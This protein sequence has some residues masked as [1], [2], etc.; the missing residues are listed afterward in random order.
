VTGPL[1]GGLARHRIKFAGQVGYAWNAALLYVK[2]GAAVA[3]QRCDIFNTLTGIDLGQAERTRWGGVVG[4]GLEYGFAPNWT[5]GIEYDYLFRESDSRTFLT[6][7]LAIGPFT[8][9]TRSDVSII[10]GRISYKFGGYGYGGPARYRSD[11]HD[12]PA[13]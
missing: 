9:N 13:N 11:L 7:N 2:G 10:T 1:I 8:A 6:P 4:V 3:S 12:Y 5:A